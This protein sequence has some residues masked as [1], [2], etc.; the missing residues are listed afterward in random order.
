MSL[1][2]EERAAIARLSPRKAKQFVHMTP[3]KRADF[4]ALCKP[5]YL[6]EIRAIRDAEDADADMEHIGW[7]MDKPP[8]QIRHLADVKQTI[9]SST[10]AR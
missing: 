1:T 6:T 3:A 2:Q 9:E 5:V 4:L 8:K 7:L 10:T